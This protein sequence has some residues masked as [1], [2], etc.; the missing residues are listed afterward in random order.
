MYKPFLSLMQ[1][2]QDAPK[3]PLGGYDLPPGWAFVV[4]VAM[5]LTALVGILAKAGVF[6]RKPATPET[7]KTRETLPPPLPA[8]P[9]SG[10]RE[11]CAA[12]IKR[13]MRNNNAKDEQIKA[14]LEG[15]KAHRELVADLLR[16]GL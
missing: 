6:S 16:K 8:P 13:E 4:A 7:D 11:T 2:G 10:Y 9:C 12:E 14:L 5:A 3:Q 1:A 15:E